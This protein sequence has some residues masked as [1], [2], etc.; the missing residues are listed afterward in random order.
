MLNRVLRLTDVLLSPDVLFPMVRSPLHHLSEVVWQL[1]QFR[2][3]LGSGLRCPDPRCLG[4]RC[5]NLGRLSLLNLNSLSYLD[6][7]LL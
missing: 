5:L 3:N 6:P 1:S 2:L 7:S 4:P